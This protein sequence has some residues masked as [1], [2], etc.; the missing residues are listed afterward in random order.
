MSA[1]S[2]LFSKLNNLINGSAPEAVEAKENN[3]ASEQ[4]K[5]ESPKSVEE[6]SKPDEDSSQSIFNNAIDKRAQSVKIITDAF[7]EA[8]GTNLSAMESLYIYVIVD[9]EDYDVKKYAWADDK[10]KQH[11][12]LSLDHAMLENVGRKM[13]SINLVT[14]ERLP[15]GAKSLID[16]TLYYAFRSA[17]PEQ[18]SFNRAVVSIV[19]G[20]GS[21]EQSEY[22]LDSKVKTTYNIGRS[23]EASSVP[24]CVNDIIV[25]NDDTDK[26]LHD[27]NVHVSRSHADISIVNGRFYIKAH[28]GGCRP[29]GGAAT[30]IISDGQTFELSDVNMKMPLAN[31]S[32]IELG[33]SVVL[34]FRTLND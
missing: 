11:L 18:I 9:C 16:G 24:G 19:K 32:L 8:T 5:Q 13:L 1:I 34:Q 30:K 6:Q 27:R 14:L 23:R 7:Q 33:K 3:L 29:L 4:P 26:T 15:Q 20:T 12:R 25:R 21:L 2:K 22:I 31:G 28:R 17:P 10:M